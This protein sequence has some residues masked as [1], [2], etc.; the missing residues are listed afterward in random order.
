MARLRGCLNCAT[1]AGCP[2]PATLHALRGRRWEVTGC[3]KRGGRGWRSLG[4]PPSSLVPPPA[5]GCV[6]VWVS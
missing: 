3:E 5:R 6:G 2:P 4:R 1:G